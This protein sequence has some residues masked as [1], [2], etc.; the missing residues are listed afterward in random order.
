M[1]GTNEILQISGANPRDEGMMRVRHLAAYIMEEIS[2]ILYEDTL[3]VRYEVL[4]FIF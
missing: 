3:R 1:H 4:K 2:A